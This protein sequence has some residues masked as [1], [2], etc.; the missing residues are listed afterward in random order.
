MGDWRLEEREENWR[1][2][3]ENCSLCSGQVRTCV[4]T[5]LNLLSIGA[6]FGF[7]YLTNSKCTKVSTFLLLNM[8]AL[9]LDFLRK[10]NHSSNRILELHIKIVLKIN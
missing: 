8:I 6:T 7:N 4:A 3:R 2:G 10:I 1:L 5:S 9:Y